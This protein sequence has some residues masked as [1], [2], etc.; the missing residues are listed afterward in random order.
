MPIDKLHVLSGQQY[1]AERDQFIARQENPPLFNRGTNAGIHNGGGT[2]LRPLPTI[3]YGYDLTQHNFNEISTYLTHALGGQ[4]ALTADQVAGLDIIRQWKSGLFT[5]VDFMQM[6]QGTFG[7]AAQITA[8]QSLT[9]TQSQ[10]TTLLDDTLDGFGGFSGFEA[11]LTRVLTN[12]AGGDIAQSK[13]RVALLDALYVGLFR[14][15]THGPTLP[16]AL[17]NADPA[18][19]RA[20]AWLFLEY[21]TLNAPNQYR[22]AI[23]AAEFG[24][25]GDNASLVDI[26]KIAG[27]VYDPVNYDY[28]KAN[29]LDRPIT[30]QRAGVPL[31]AAM[32]PLIQRLQQELTLNQ[33]VDYVEVGRAGVDGVLTA[34]QLSQALGGPV[35]RP[36]NNLM[37]GL[38]GNDTLTAGQGHDVLY[39]GGGNDTLIANVVAN[40]GQV[41]TLVGGAFD[42]TAPTAQRTGHDMLYA[43]I[44]SNVL[45]GDDNEATFSVDANRFPQGYNIIWGDSIGLDTYNFVGNNLVYLVNISGPSLQSVQQY[46]SSPGAFSNFFATLTGFAPGA[47]GE[48][49][50]IIINPNANDTLNLNGTSLSAGRYM[51]TQ[52]APGDKALLVVGDNQNYSPSSFDGMVVAVGAGDTIDQSATN[53]SR[54]RVLVANHG[55]GGGSNTLVAGSANSIMIS[56]G[57]DTTF[58]IDAEKNPNA[59]T[60]IWANGGNDTYNFRGH[61]YVFMVDDPNAT[62]QSVE[63]LDVN[64]LA[65]AVSTKEGISADPGSAVTIIISPLKN[66]HL[67]VGGVLGGGASYAPIYT[68][69]YQPQ[70]AGDV[71]NGYTLYGYRNGGLN[72]YPSFDAYAPQLQNEIYVGT[73]AGYDSANLIGFVNGDLG[74]TISGDGPFMTS[75]P[76]PSSDYQA[77][78]PAFF[79]VASSPQIDLRQY[80]SSPIGAASL[81]VEAAGGSSAVANASGE[82]VSLSATSVT[83]VATLLSSNTSDTLVSINAAVAVGSN[84]TLIGGTGIQ[85]LQSVGSFNS[86]LAGL[87]ADTLVSAGTNDTLFGNGAGS[88]LDGSGGVTTV[89]A[90]NLANVVVDL[91]AGLAQVGGSGTD[92]LVGISI[93]DALG[94][95]DTLIAGGEH[96]TLIA[97][98]YADTLI[99]N[100][101]GSR[102]DTSSGSLTTVGYIRDQVTVN[103]QAG[104]A[105]I[106]GSVSGDTLIGVSAVSAYGNGDTLLGGATTTTLSALGSADVL[107]GGTGATTLISNGHSNTLLGSD[108]STVALYAMDGVTVDLASGTAAAT[109]GVDTLIGITNVVLSGNHSTARAGVG[110]DTLSAIGIA[111]VLIGGDGADTLFS[112]TT[113]NTLVAGTGA[114][115]LETGGSFDTLIGAASGNT[116]ISLGAKNTLIAG[117]GVNSLSTRGSNDTLFGNGAG[118]T[119]DA[120]A[121]RS[122]VAA[123]LLDNVAIDVAAGTATV[124]GSG[125]SDTLLGFTTIAALGTNDTLYDGSNGSTLCSSA[126]G[127]TLVGGAGQTV[128][129]YAGDHVTVDLG[130]GTASLNGSVARDTLIGIKAGILAG[131]NGTLLG[132]SGDNLLYSS[133]S[134]NTLV[135]GTG[136]DTLLSTGTGDVLVGNLLG[137]TLLGSYSQNSNHQGAVAAYSA[138]DITIDLSAQTAKRNGAGVGDLLVAINTVGAFGSNDTLIG[139]SGSTLISNAA[140]NTLIAQASDV[141]ALYELDGVTVDLTEGTVSVGGASSSD[142]LVGVRAATVTGVNDTLIGDGSGD[143]LTTGNASDLVIYAADNVSV[144]LRAGTAGIVGASVQDTLVGIRNVE[145]FGADDLITGGMAAVKM[146]AAGSHDT[147]VGNLAGS[148]LRAAQSATGTVALYSFDEVTVDLGLGVASSPLSSASDTLIGL[149]AVALAGSYGT[150]LAGTSADTLISTGS[151]NSLVGGSGSSTLSSSGYRDI[152]VAGSGTQSLASQGGGNTLIAGGA[153]DLLTSTGIGD[154]LVGNGLG[155]T[156]N[157]TGGSGVVAVYAIDNVKVDLQT[158]RAGVNGSAIVDTL[159]EI[160]NVVVLGAHDTIVAGSSASVLS[161]SGFNNSLIGGDGADTLS[162]SGNGDTL[163]AGGGDNILSSSGAQNILVAGSGTDVLFSSGTSDVLLGGSGSDTIWSSGTGNTLIAGSGVDTLSSVGTGDTLLGNGLGSTLDGSS[164]VDVVAAYAVNNVTVDL[165]TGRATVAGSAVSDTLVGINSVLLLGGHDALIGGTNATTF[166]SNGAA[167]TLI[168]GAGRA[169]VVYKL[170]NVMVDLTAAANDGSNT[171]DVLIGISNIVASGS[172][173]TIIGGMD[174]VSLSSTGSFNTLVAGAGT[175]LLTSS[176]IGDTLLGGSGPETL[177]SSG[178]GNTLVAGGAIDTLSSSG[179]GDVLV[180]NA[181]GSTLDGRGGFGAVA[182]YAINNVT[183]DLSSGTAAVNGSGVSDILLGITT[184]FAGGANDTLIGGAEAA[185]LFSDCNGN[186]L[187]AGAGQTTVA[188]TLDGVTVDL[189]S[190]SATVD[191]STTGDALIGISSVAVYGSDDIVVGASGGEFLLSNG[192]GNTL[193]AGGGAGSLVSLGFGDTLIGNALGSTLDGSNGVGT[194]AAYAVD[195]ATVNLAEGLAAI[196]GSSVADTLVGI[197]IATVSGIGDTLIGN[198][199]TNTLSAS[200]SNDVVIA[201]SGSD[202]LM[203]NRGDNT[204]IAGSGADTFVASASTGHAT[205]IANDA[206]GSNSELDFT[207]GITNENLWFVQSGNDLEIDLLGSSTSVTIKD[208]CSDGESQLQEITAGGLKIDNQVSQLVQAMATFSASTPGFD[209]TSPALQVAPNDAGVQ[210][211]IAAAWHA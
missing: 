196:V 120:S 70:S 182:E 107:A 152:L 93:A 18:I 39:G 45:I 114:N 23:E 25:A 175:P 166:Y 116:L 194:I 177:S 41:G 34:R 121:G 44:G 4:Q 66:G 37:I 10:A 7:T 142:T 129:S 174:A 47:L 16:A 151:F 198:A 126:A 162:T 87:G 125:V 90:Y 185:T 134:S 13:E 48:S 76:W 118:S 136:I 36:T 22:R 171:S 201:G 73:Q 8:V 169:T 42:P 1:V 110:P 200:G 163:I 91:A 127:N 154:S 132:G 122:A 119:L 209:A 133:G 72:Y 28:I 30:G 21:Y 78:Q 187:Q 24:V 40:G 3:G 101:G 84:D 95:Y 54:T 161:S 145:V 193:I 131:S 92:I 158:G 113:R 15:P 141:T 38:D 197:N 97:A 55:S 210:N 204:Y 71:A 160:A 33:V 26:E 186:T 128:A 65:S 203:M 149:T 57:V 64:A 181:L 52:P 69:N 63:N 138:N 98:G 140:G 206:P 29:G 148:T 89:A 144:D 111:D 192:F 179:Y 20:Q 11:T 19:A 164:G 170:D 75:Y 43:G 61:N 81:F 80:Q 183:V 53:S 115:L 49:A 103:L 58:N 172:G 180:G 60:V 82:V 59:V 155:S 176:G 199:G 56:D 207:D 50:T 68:Y 184:A 62:L 189:A 202:T 5:T 143:T 17:S 195:N 130:A 94:A 211:A 99:G 165:T 168:A 51:R 6:V 12:K 167:N 153:A 156:L 9:L 88:T 2:A 173:D 123:Y 32:Q 96:E 146:T 112:W 147:L 159:T 100:G 31:Q 124:S 208:W 150:L 14:N 108:G 85:T 117:A 102:L 27:V 67:N 105:I 139:S 35:G 79:S 188:Y 190:Q 109:N 191:G 157:G 86:L 77:I 46:A 74:V 83:D 104:T 137:S 106:G 178:Q 205:V 135:A